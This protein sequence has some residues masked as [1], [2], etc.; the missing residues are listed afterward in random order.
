MV[1]TEAVEATTEVEEEEGVP[2]T[3]I[4][5]AAA[6]EAEDHTEVEDHTATEVEDH[7]AAVM[8]VRKLEQS[9]FFRDLFNLLCL[10]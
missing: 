1:I 2:E 6:V 7:T 9:L 5:A 10:L 3:D 4:T 8:E